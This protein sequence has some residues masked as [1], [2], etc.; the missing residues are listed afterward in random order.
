MIV[1][2]FLYNFNIHMDYNCDTGTNII[3]YIINFNKC[4]RWG[5]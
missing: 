5:I 3:N 4:I 1:I 2:Y